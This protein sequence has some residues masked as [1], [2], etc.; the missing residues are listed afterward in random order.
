MKTIW[1]RIHRWL[2]EHAPDVLASLAPAATDEQIT[3][4]LPVFV[5]QDVDLAMYSLTAGMSPSGYSP[6]A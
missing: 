2:A 1:D 4:T 3:E 6:T 5:T